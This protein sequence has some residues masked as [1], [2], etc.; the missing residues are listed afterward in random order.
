MIYN[1]ANFSELQCATPF[2]RMIRPDE[3]WLYKNPRA[4]SYIPT[5]VLWEGFTSNCRHKTL[6][7]NELIYSYLSALFGLLT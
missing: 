7:Y 4:D 3:L 2:S 5:S 1:F 6:N